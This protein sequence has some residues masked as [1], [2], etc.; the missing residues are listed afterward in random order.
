[1]PA[2]KKQNKD[3]KTGKQQDFVLVL[4]PNDNEIHS[5]AY[6]K[7]TSYQ[8]SA[9]GVLHDKDV[10]T[11]DKVDE[12]TGEFI[13]KAGDLKK[14]HY[15]FYV[16]FRNQRY[17]NGVAE[18]LNIEPHLIE[19]CEYGFVNYAEYMLHWG[20]HGG[21]GKYIYDVDCFEG[22]LA[23]V[24]KNKLTNEPLEL[25]QHKIYEFIKNYNGLINYAIVYEWA[26]KNGY[27]GICSSKIAFVDRLIQC[28]NDKFFNMKKNTYERRNN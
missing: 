13:H 8:Y 14:P 27:G 20:K 23:G 18:E 4:Y 12:E 25:R 7:L 28:H 26:Y 6:L 24:A 2:R 5:L 10:Y 21:A 17:I 11:D 16:K 15:H 3:R 22:T 9:L 19:F 1:M